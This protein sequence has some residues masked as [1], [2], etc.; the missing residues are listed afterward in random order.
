[1]NT[2]FVS[3]FVLGS[4]DLQVVP[5]SVTRDRSLNDPG[6]SHITEITIREFTQEK[7]LGTGSVMG[8]HL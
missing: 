2:V 4:G 3:L 7:K 8:M 6:L 1:M 5:A